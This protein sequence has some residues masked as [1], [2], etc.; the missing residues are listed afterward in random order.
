M[1]VKA[2]GKASRRRV[3]RNFFEADE[4][5]AQGYAVEREFFFHT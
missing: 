2:M 3:I 5:E 1:R 4:L